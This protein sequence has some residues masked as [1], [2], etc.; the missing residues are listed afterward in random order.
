MV[1]LVTQTVYSFERCFQELRQLVANI[2]I[3]KLGFDPMESQYGM[4]DGQRDKGTIFER[5]L[6]LSPVGV[7]P[8]VLLI[9][10]SSATDAVLSWQSTASLSTTLLSL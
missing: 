9:L 5:I 7:I 10:Y 8:T 6:Q 4:F 1:L 3:W 2:S